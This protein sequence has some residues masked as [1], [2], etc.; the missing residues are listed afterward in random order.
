MSVFNRKFSVS[1][2]RDNFRGSDN[3]VLY[4]QR[5]VVIK[6]IKNKSNSPNGSLHTITEEDTNAA[7]SERRKMTEDK[8]I[9]QKILRKVETIEFREHSTFDTVTKTSFLVKRSNKKVKFK[10]D[11]HFVDEVIVESYKKYH[12]EENNIT[13]RKKDKTVSCRCLIF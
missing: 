2:L 12:Q 6:K 3:K 11:P 13:R 8:K 7:K 10:D 1:D 4:R 9:E 5:T